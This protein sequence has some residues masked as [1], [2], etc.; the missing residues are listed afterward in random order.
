MFGFSFAFLAFCLVLIWSTLLETRSRRP[1]LVN[2]VYW[3]TT[4]LFAASLIVGAS[5]Q[6]IANP[7]DPSSMRALHYAPLVAQASVM[8]A[9]VALAGLTVHWRWTGSYEEEG[10]DDPS[11]GDASSSAD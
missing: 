3:G 6:A 5:A 2:A 4:G 8:L 9:L 10:S 11:D 1:G 7:S